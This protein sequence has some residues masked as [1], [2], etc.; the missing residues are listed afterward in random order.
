MPLLMMCYDLWVMIDC[1]PFSPLF[2]PCV[3]LLWFDSALLGYTDH[4]RQA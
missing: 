4:Y 3:D 2:I 1:S